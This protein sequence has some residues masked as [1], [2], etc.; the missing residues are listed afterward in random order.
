M[1][2]FVRDDDYDESKRM[3]GF[4]RYKQLLSFFSGHW[5]ILNIITFFAALPL[6]IS[7]TL[8]I[9]SSSILILIPSCFISGMILGPFLAA[10]ADSIQ[11]GL[12]EDTNNRW[13]NYK[14]GLRQNI[15]CSLIPGAIL[16]L[17][18]G[19]YSFLFYMVV[20]T[21]AITLSPATIALILFS[22][23]LVLNFQNL[24]WP[25]LV[26]FNQPFKMTFLNILLFSSKYLWKVLGIVLL[27]MIYIAFFIIFAP[28]TLIVVPFLGIWY[29]IFF[30]QF[31][32]YDKLNLELEIEKRYNL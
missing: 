7:I 31:L 22:I 4:N 24:Y 28:V 5:T 25:Q 20:Y 10:L 30:S 17:F 13:Q 21:D 32:L 29:F 11:R 18:I 15:F 16:G 23:I 6:M 2:L 8:S 14:K 27:E 12:R 1:G 9:L 26:L 19:V 3:T